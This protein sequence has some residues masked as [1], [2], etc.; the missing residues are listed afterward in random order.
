M[1]RMAAD[2]TA[3]SPMADLL[4]DLGKGIS[5]QALSSHMGLGT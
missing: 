5:Q 1:D 3:N 2:E 4:P